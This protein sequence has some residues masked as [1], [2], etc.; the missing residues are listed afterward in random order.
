VPGVIGANDTRQLLSIEIDGQAVH[1][2]RLEFIDG[3][4]LGHA[5]YLS[6]D[7]VIGMGELCAHVD[8]ALADI[9]HPGLERILQWEP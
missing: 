5:G 7:V 6:G 1:V 4:S 8:K 2:R 3:Q 9:E